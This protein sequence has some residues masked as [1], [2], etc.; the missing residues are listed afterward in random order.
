MTE[1]EI[2]NAAIEYRR[3]ELLT[4]KEYAYVTRVHVRSV[5]RR[6]RRGQQPGAVRVGGQWRV[7]L[8]VALAAA[9]GAHTAA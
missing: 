3:N 4:V 7:D 6:I 8:I 5:R 9:S 1:Q 2:R